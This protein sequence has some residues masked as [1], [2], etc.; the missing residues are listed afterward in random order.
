MA[1]E[2]HANEAQAYLYE[3]IEEANLLIPTLKKNYV[4]LNQMNTLLHQL[5]KDVRNQ[6]FLFDAHEVSLS[7]DMEPSMMDTIS[8][9][10][11]LLAAIQK[12]LDKLNKLGIHFKSIDSGVVNILMKKK[13]QPIHLIWNVGDTAILYWEEVDATGNC[14]RRPIHELVLSAEEELEE[15]DALV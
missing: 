6:D 4:R 14:K 10:K 11:L 12:E 7:S 15:E 13:G 3:T 9:I 8:S 5:L 2:P 1:D